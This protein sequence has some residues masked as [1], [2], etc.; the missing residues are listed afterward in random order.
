MV[1]PQLDLLS[2]VEG[3]T[4][5][6]LLAQRGPFLRF[7]PAL[8]STLI[9]W[10]VL[11]HARNPLALPATLLAIPLAFYAVLYAAGVSLADAQ[12]AAWVPQPAEVRPLGYPPRFSQYTTSCI[13][14]RCMFAKRHVLTG[15]D[16]EVK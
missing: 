11:Q 1:T 3:L 8:G 4:S 2:Q 16:S 9:L 7:L 6:V 5:W 13:F 12:A 14:V 10:A 15:F